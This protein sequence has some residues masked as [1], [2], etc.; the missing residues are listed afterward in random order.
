[1]QKSFFFF[2]HLYPC[3]KL[4]PRPFAETVDLG[5]ETTCMGSPKISRKNKRSE[6]SD[7]NILKAKAVKS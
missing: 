5:K 6:L 2:K 3:I 4:Q 1:M 7:T